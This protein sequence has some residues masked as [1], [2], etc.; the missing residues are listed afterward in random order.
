MYWIH[1]EVNPVGLNPVDMRSAHASGADGIASPVRN[2]AMR[3]SEHASGAY[4]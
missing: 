3:Q 2:R 1:S 4:G